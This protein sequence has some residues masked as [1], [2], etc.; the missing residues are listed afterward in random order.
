MSRLSQIRQ[1]RVRR[2]HRARATT[3]GSA[4][5]PRLSV[6]ISAK[7]VSAQII[8]DELGQTLAAATTIGK[9]IKQPLAQQAAVIGT[10]IAQAAQKAKIKQVVLDRGARRY[11]GRLKA[12]AEAA[13]KQGLEF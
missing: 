11:H 1:A 9:V 13:R 2:A 3:R 8:N 10:E 6:K 5:R 12:L 7:N 4:Q